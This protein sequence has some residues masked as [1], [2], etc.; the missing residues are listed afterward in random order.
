MGEAL[1][2]RVVGHGL[3]PE[4]AHGLVAGK[5][6][7]NLAEDE[8]ALAARVTGV[9]D[10]VDVVALNQLFQGP[11]S[12]GLARFGL[13]A[14]LL[15][16]DGEII[17]EPALVLRVDLLGLE[18][19]EE[20][21]DSETDDVAPAL[22]VPLVLGKAAEGRSDIPSDAGLFGDDEGL[23]HGAPMP[24][25]GGRLVRPGGNGIHSPRPLG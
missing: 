6:L 19:L 4:P 16:K 15:R 22:G 20:V 3:E 14:E 7:R 12:L 11:D 10:Q 9:H 23:R 8:L 18:Q 2:D 21:S 25:G 1:A 5:M 17:E 13:E 24:A